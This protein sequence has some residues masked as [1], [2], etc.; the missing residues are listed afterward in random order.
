MYLFVVWGDFMF[1]FKNINSGLTNVIGLTDEL[2]SIY[3]NYIY[4]INNNDIIIVTNSTYEAN[5]LYNS[6]LNYNNNIFL[7]LMDDF[8]TSQSS[9]CS[10]EMEINR[11]ETIN[12]ILK[13]SNKK[14]V[15]TNLMGYLRFLPSKKLWEQS[16]LNL[17][18]G[19][20]ISKNLLFNKLCEL[21][22]NSDILVNKTG[23]VSN[24]GY[25]LDV[26]PISE[27]DP[28]RIEFWGD[29]IESIRYF[30]VDSQLSIKKINNIII[31]PCSEFIVE[32]N[33]LNLEKKQENLIKYSTAY[34]IIDYINK[35][36]IVYFNYSLIYNSYLKLQDDICEF[37]IINKKNEKYMFDLE[38]M[39]SE[40]EIYISSVDDILPNLKIDDTHIYNCSNV[41]FFDDSIENLKK[42]IIKN[43]SNNKIVVLSLDNKVQFKNM[44]DYLDINYVIT[45]QN[46]LKQNVLNVI[47]K[48]INNGYCINDYVV[49]S[50]KNIF[51]NNNSKSNYKTK[52]K[53]GTKISNTNSLN[54]GDY[55]VHNIHGIGIYKGI[56]ALNKNNIKKDYL[57]IEYKDNGKLYIPVEKIDLISKYSSNDGIIPKINK[58][59][60]NEWH[61]TKLRVKGKLKNIASDLLK[62]TAERKMKLGFSFLKDTAEQS[63]FESE[64]IYTETKD[65][66]NATKTIKKY[67]ESSYPMDVLLCGDV[68][69]GKTE[70]AFRAIF[71]AV[72]SNK[73]VAY[74]C[75]TTILSNQQFK[76]A[77]DRFKNFPVNIA[78]LN[79]F[80]NLNQVKKILNDLKEGK[81]DILFGTHRI[82]SDDV[83]FKDLGLLI[84]DEEQRF[85]VLHKEKI[86]KIKSN[87]DVITLSA[88][89]IPRTLQMSMVGIRDLVLIETPPVDRYPV[90]TYVLEENDLII[91]DV[92]YKELSR[93]GQVFILCN[94]INLFE[95]RID[96]FSKLIPD[97]KIS[98]AHGKMS[99]NEIENKMMEFINGNFDVLLCTTIIETG[100]DIPN[101]NTIIILDAD[102]LGLSQLYQI[103]GRVGRT[104]KI[105]YAYLMY[106]KNKILSEIAIKRLSAMKEF[107]K[108]GSGF[109]IA[110]RD[111]SIRGAGDVLGEEQ[112]GFIDSIGIELYL[113]MLNDEVKKLKGEESEEFS[114][115]NDVESENV[116]LNVQT[117][118]DDKYTTDDNLKIEIH[119]LINQINSFESLNRVKCEIEDRFGKIDENMKIYMY[120]ELFESM[121]K[122]KGI[123]NVK[124]NADNIEITF[125]F[126]KS[127]NIN[128]EKLFV[129]SYKICKNF[130]LKYINKKIVLILFIKN[131]DKHWIY[132]LIEILNNI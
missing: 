20:N 89:P 128:A 23:D 36:I 57:M 76:S 17:S 66:L 121:K 4:N 122:D 86:K 22:Y 2:S 81:I 82:L 111:L 11:I 103:R 25:I 58:L 119:K 130:K 54:I 129:E 53:Y 127:Q 56:I 60:G 43:L 3:I 68:G 55:I 100:I 52:F 64:F 126:D 47:F 77:L 106:E 49:I 13:T 123:E 98:Y 109:S 19:M 113:K 30:D 116:S 10:P 83:I 35:P 37:N 15:I 6:L 67:M 28:V 99:K 63:V 107:A 26:F 65:Q 61:K 18:T 94:R 16:T 40:K 21:G 45:N 73:Q 92:I 117:H 95:K 93:N 69:Y 74:L 50:S 124:Q 75:P 51:K 131:L 32:D 38:E 125:T 41:P 1:N 96:E 62:I 27:S 9:I 80:T 112:S 24:R 78:L 120:E 7:F 101:V 132:Y 84:I 46:D 104:N 12:S 105:A 115:D 70:V 31:N 114:D 88:T 48:N 118:I 85:G 44:I 91:K 33:N 42:F 90:Q 108:L 5:K 14:I 59:G 110:L 34:K 102:K 39:F 97:V 79:R 8:I 71:K 29:E 87:V 72:C